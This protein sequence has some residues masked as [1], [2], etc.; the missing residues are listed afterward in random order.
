MINLFQFGQAN[1]PIKHLI[2]KKQHLIN[3]AL[4]V[5]PNAT[6]NLCWM[7]VW[8]YPGPWLFFTGAIPSDL[9]FMLTLTLISDNDFAQKSVVVAA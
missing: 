6:H 1:L 2:C 4:A 3:Q 5:S 7:K 9:L 8:F